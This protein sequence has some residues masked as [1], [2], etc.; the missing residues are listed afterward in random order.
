MDPV[1]TNNWRNAS[2]DPVKA[3]KRADGDEPHSVIK[4]EAHDT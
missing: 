3:S 1:S 4:I 2:N